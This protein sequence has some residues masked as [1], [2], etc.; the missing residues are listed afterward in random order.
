MKII[1]KSHPNSKQSR[2]SE[3][4]PGIFDVYIS[5]PAVDGKANKAITQAIAEYFDV[6][7][8]LVEIIKGHTSKTKVL[9]LPD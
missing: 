8:S 6:A 1:V 5:S 2:I 3:T 9:Q 4:E 7:P